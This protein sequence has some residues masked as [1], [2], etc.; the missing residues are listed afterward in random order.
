MHP[1]EVVARAATRP[2]RRDLLLA[3]G[4]LVASLVV[5][6]PYV[7]G[8][9]GFFVD[10]W[11]NLARLDTVGWLRSAE[12]SRF[13]SRPGAWAVETVLYP[14]LRDRAVAWVLA[15]TLLNASAAMAVLVA[16]RRFMSHRVAL[17]VVLVWIA[18]PN[19]TSLRVFANV[20]PMVVGLLLLAIAVV[21]IDSDRPVLGGLA[22]AGAGMCLEAMLLPGLVA[23]VALHRMRGRGDRRGVLIGAGLVVPTGALMLIHP[24]YSV[25]G[26]HRGTPVH[27]LPAHFGS[28]LTAIG[29]VGWVLGAL[30]AVGVTAGVVQFARGRRDPGNGPWLVMVGLMVMALGLAAFVLKW[31]VGSRGQPDRNFA[32]SS[33][34]SAMVW[35]GVSTVIFRRGGG[36][37]G[38]A[39]VAGV[40]L[41]HSNVAFQ[42]DWSRSAR[43]ARDMVLAVHCR[44]DGDP[45][46]GLSVG[47]SVPIPGGVRPLHEFYV[48]DASR[49]LVGRPMRFELAE[50]PGEWVTA[51]PELRLTWRE[52]LADEACQR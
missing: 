10:D 17:A 34:G 31:P 41:V 49:V 50:D 36:R 23:L 30:A 1:N 20:A 39:V 8:D 40:L 46:P 16:L 51:P 11:R 4:L 24:T 44:F 18:L 15:L 2:D 13:A 26:A 3:S 32:L 27:V 19:H 29:W 52:L 42:A 14:V 21:L 45:P 12:A 28:G 43:D 25:S 6:L 9:P 33:V 5:V 35:V 48:E 7:L 22:V 37:L 47:P 38:A